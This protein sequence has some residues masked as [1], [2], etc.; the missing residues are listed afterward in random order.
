MWCVPSAVRNR[1]G[2][3]DRDA[4]NIGGGDGFHAH[5][6]PTNNAL[7]LQS[8]QNGNAAW[9][10]IETLERQ[11]ARPGSG[12]RP[13]PPVAGVGRGGRGGGGG[14]GG[15]GRGGGYR[16]N[17]DTPIVVSHH[18]PKTWF[19]G[20]QML[21]KSTDRGS[22]WQQISGDLTLNADRDTLKMMGSVV[23]ADALS[24]H[25]G[26]SNYG[27]LTS[28]GESPV[29]PLLIYT[30]SDDGQVQVTKDGGKTWTN[31]TKTFQ[32]CRSDVRQHVCRRNKQDALCDL[33]GH[34]TDDY[35]P[36]VFVSEDSGATWRSL[37]NGLPETSI[38][39]IRE[40]PAQPAARPG[41][42]ARRALLE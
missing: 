21:F 7:V 10:N 25:D 6:D 32:A 23:P 26:Q 8:S 18:D 24:R 17:W 22:S 14:G 1:N 40:H 12:D 20:A 33:D 39:R 36:Y 3:A 30:G 2:I 31:I 27:S 38:N 19:M 5:F 29:N 11:G 35:K 13:E 37:S 34:Y 28:I 4:W 15:G 16:W 41:T 9:V 42:R